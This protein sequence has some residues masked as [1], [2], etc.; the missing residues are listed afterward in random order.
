MKWRGREKE[1]DLKGRSLVV[2]TLQREGWEGTPIY[3]TLYILPSGR[4]VSIYSRFLCV[5]I[6]ISSFSSWPPPVIPVYG[7]A[8]ALV[9]LAFAVIGGGGVGE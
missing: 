9:A 1:N 6:N 4:Y 3:L 5:C 7:L 2:R 8:A